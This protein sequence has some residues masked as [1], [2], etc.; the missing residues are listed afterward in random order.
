MI[1]ISNTK[2]SVTIGQCALEV[3]Q[4]TLFVGYDDNVRYFILNST[5]ENTYQLSV[6]VLPGAFEFTTEVQSFFGERRLQYVGMF[7]V[8]KLWLVLLLKFAC[9]SDLEFSNGCPCEGRNWLW[10][11]LRCNYDG[12][13]IVTKALSLLVVIPPTQSFLHKR[14]RLEA[15][16]SV[17]FMPASLSRKSRA[18][19]SKH[20]SEQ[21]K[22]VL[23]A[24]SPQLP[25][26]SPC[27]TATPSPA[28]SSWPI[29][30]KRSIP[31]SS[32][33]SA[34]SQ[35]QLQQGVILSTDFIL[36]CLHVG[37]LVVQNCSGAVRLDNFGNLRSIGIEGSHSILVSGKLH[38][39][40]T[41]M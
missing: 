31:P 6:E 37:G 29:S 17:T 27:A 25:P 16:L 4:R 41:R 28:H 9:S 20:C 38:R 33:T 22:Y 10:C 36:S 18:A 7:I 11:R 35:V 34:Q 19:S 12:K 1:R 5:T 2:A 8:A 32:G 13:R 23:V 21:R 24:H 40:S 26:S 3:G 30:R 15:C 39:S 14:A